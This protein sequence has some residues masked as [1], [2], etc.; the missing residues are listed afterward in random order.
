MKG[1]GGYYTHTVEGD[2]LTDAPLM[3]GGGLFLVHFLFLFSE[4]G[5]PF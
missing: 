2:V 1:G 4:Q 5:K 3:E